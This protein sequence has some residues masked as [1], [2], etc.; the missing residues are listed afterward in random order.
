MW[1]FFDFTGDFRFIYFIITKH[2]LVSIQFVKCLVSIPVFKKFDTRL[3]NLSNQLKRFLFSSFCS[4]VSV[5][6]ELFYD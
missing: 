2:T 4:S 6:T 3:L 1:F 5:P